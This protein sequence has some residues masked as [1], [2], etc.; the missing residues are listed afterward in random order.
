MAIC[1]PLSLLLLFTLYFVLVKWIYPNR[2]KS[3]PSTKSMIKS[4]VNKLG[5][6]SAA[7][8]RVLIIFICTA[9]LWITKDLINKLNV[10]KLDDTVIVLAGAVALFDC[11]SGEKT[12][13]LF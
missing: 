12:K 8:K 3:D 13:K 10:I 2:M 9:A 4:E 7:E 6:M 1:M 11:P 5:N